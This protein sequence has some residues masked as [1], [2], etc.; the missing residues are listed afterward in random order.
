MWRYVCEL[1]AKSV[2]QWRFYASTMMGQPRSDTVRM[3]D[4]WSSGILC[5]CKVIISF[6]VAVGPSAPGTLFP[7]SALLCLSHHSHFLQSAPAHH[8]YSV[9]LVPQCSRT[10]CSRIA[11][12]HSAPAHHP[13]SVCLGAQ[14]T[15]HP[16]LAFV[17]Q[18]PNP[19][20]LDI[21][22]MCCCAV[23]V[24]LLCGGCD[25]DQGLCPSLDLTLLLFYNC[26]EGSGIAWVLATVRAVSDYQGH[27]P[28]LS[29]SAGQLIDVIKVNNTTW[30][31]V[32]IPTTRTATPTKTTKTQTCNPPDIGHTD[33]WRRG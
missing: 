30:W 5:W 25:G 16:P 15:L 19:Q 29:Y 28:E 20:F 31:K 1:L 22:L 18:H 10:L 13:Y 27:G 33:D 7:Q 11:A 23:V 6:S 2:V 12:A 17:R 21:Q 4:W 8:S 9:R 24:V 32:S 26:A 14:C 3:W